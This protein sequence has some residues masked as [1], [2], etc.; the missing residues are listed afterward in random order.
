MFHI[1]GGP[2]LKLETTWNH[3]KYQNDVNAN[4]DDDDNHDRSDK[5]ND[6]EEDAH[7][8]AA[9]AAAGEEEDEDSEDKH[10]RGT[11]KWTENSRKM[12]YI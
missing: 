11:G 3:I 7:C 8:E 5:H 4:N 12:Q 6:D 9:V 2:Q 1:F 10:A